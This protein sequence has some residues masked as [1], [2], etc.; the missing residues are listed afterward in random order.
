VWKPT[1][2]PIEID[3][4]DDTALCV[5]FFLFEEDN[6]EI[7]EELI[8]RFATGT[9]PIKLPNDPQYDGILEKIIERFS[10]D[11][12]ATIGEKWPQLV[13]AI[14]KSVLTVAP[15]VMKELRKDDV[16]DTRVIGYDL[17]NTNTCYLPREYNLAGRGGKYKVGMQLSVCD[18]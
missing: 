15:G 12:V 6:G 14:L 18:G 11:I 7:R 1:M 16:I 3:T 17:M 2:D 5:L 13:L 8:K 9:W 4:G 10:E